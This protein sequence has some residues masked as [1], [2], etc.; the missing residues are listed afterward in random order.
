MEYINSETVCEMFNKLARVS[1]KSKTIVLDNAK[2]Q[3]CDM[4]KAHAEKL[5]IELLYLPSYSPN[6]NLI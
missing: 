4:V 2:Y 6:L 5:G 1:K 3:R